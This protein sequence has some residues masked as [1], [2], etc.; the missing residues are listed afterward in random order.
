MKNLAITAT[1]LDGGRHLLTHP[2]SLSYDASRSVPCDALDVSFPLQCEGVEFK[3]LEA[4]LGGEP[5]FTGIVDRQTVEKGEGGNLLRFSCRSRAALLIDNEVKPYV[6]FYLTPGEVLERYGYPYG[7]LGAE[8]P[9]APRLSVLQVKKGASAW[10][11]L[12]DFCRQ[13]YQRT[14]YLTKRQQL[15]LSPLTGVERTLTDYSRIVL[16][17]KNDKLISKVYV[18][19]VNDAYGAYYGFSSEGA[20]AINR[21][22]RRERYVHP[23]LPE[24]SDEE[25]FRL[26]RD[27]EYESFSVELTFPGLVEADI[28]DGVLLPRE[29]TLRPLVV[30]ETAYRISESGVTTRLTLADRRCFT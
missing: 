18:K 1:D 13:R 28:G 26:I 11:V 21:G 29:K 5:F 30:S 17:Q 8:L 4:S 24:D 2:L 14:P 16:R 9:N 22:V 25:I 6:Y 27:A 3:G 23:A 7:V 19:T 15:V 10:Q 20:M 12:T